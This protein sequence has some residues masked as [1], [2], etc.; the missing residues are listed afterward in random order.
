MICHRRKIVFIHIPRTGGQSI[1][2]V[3]FPNFNFTDKE[4]RT[5]L[6]GWNKKLGWLNHLTCEEILRNNFISINGFNNY[7]RFAFVRNPWERL[8]SEYA[9]KFSG[10]IERFRQFCIDITEKKYN[11]W[12]SQYRDLLALKQH[13]RE[14]YKY[15]FDSKGK[16]AVDFIGRY[17]NLV[18]DFQQVS[19]LTG[20]KYCKLPFLNKSGHKHYTGYYDKLTKELVERTYKDDIEIFNY[21][22]G[23]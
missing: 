5:I 8:V 9:W 13:I 23:D 20:L 6:Y 1:E 15:V 12:A 21:H 18:E 10:E 7:F 16:L 22:F 19:K 3:L 17:E 2:N 11:N 4:E 14:Q